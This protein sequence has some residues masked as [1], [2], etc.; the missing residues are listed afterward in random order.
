M[1][2]LSYDISKHLIIIFLVI[3]AYWPTYSGGFILDDNGLIKNN[4]LYKDPHPITTYFNQEDVKADEK[5]LGNYHSGYYRPLINLTYRLD[6][7]LWGMEA[8]GFRITNVILHLLC[9]F[10]ILHFFSL[11]FK[12]DVV[13][14]DTLI[15]ALHPVNTESI[16]FIASRNN[17]IATIF[18]IGSLSSYIIAHQRGNLKA[19][20]VS[21]ILFAGAIFSKEFG[22]MVLPLFFLYHRLLAEEKVAL[23]KETF[24]YIPFIIIVVIYLFLRK[25]VTESVIT[26]S[27]IADIGKN[28][29]RIYFVPF[30]IFYN[31]KIL[32]FPFNLHFFHIT[33]PENLYNWIN[34]SS[35][36][37]LIILFITLWMIRKNR[38]MV[39]S[40]LA[41]LLCITPVLNI[42]PTSS[43]SLISMRWLYLPMIFLFLGICP[44]IIKAITKRRD[45]SVSIL[46]VIITYLGIYTYTLNKGLWHD[47]DTLIKQEVFGFDN[48][49]FS[50]DIAEKYYN[51]RQ[52][53]EAERY[54][55]IA[56]EEFPYQALNYII[57]SALLIE[58]GRTIDAV[59]LLDK[60]KKLVMTHHEQ[61]QWH[62]NMGIALWAKGDKGAALKHL[63]KAVICAPEEEIFW[64]NLGAAYGIKGDYNKSINILKEGVSFSPKSVQLK[65]SL[66]KGYINLMDYQ[67]AVLILEEIPGNERP[68]NMDILRLLEIARNGINEKNVD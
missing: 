5:D 42:I 37:L 47:E 10:I 2:T 27:D 24:S 9:C 34:L 7:I 64:A 48:L 57:Y 3:A 63:N 12:R 20:I 1:K 39:F 29:E 22:L 58:T 45:V 52:Y 16:S 54:F 55:K 15:F 44:Y 43:V 67:K 51:N 68:G 31:L 53:S 33:Y 13:F 38:L 61:G 18:F 23:L 32:I 59:T 62:N 56:I 19:Y 46:I 66:A 35:F 49:L 60:A 6:Y 25:S 17:I 11:F 65:I 4:P 36:L 21:V 28:W 14:W 40:I 30:L 26:P 41:F 50:L 8:R